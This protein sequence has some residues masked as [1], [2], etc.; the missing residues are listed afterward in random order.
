MSSNNNLS[1]EL[2]K[3]LFSPTDNYLQHELNRIILRARETLGGDITDYIFYSVNYMGKTYTTDGG[4]INIV[5]NDQLPES[6]YSRM[7]KYIKNTEEFKLSK[8][9]ISAY[10][11]RMLNMVEDP[12]MLNKVC[13]KPLHRTIMDFGASIQESVALTPTQLNL[14]EIFNDLNKDIIEEI[15][16]LLVKN[17]L[18]GNM[19]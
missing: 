18:I 16:A 9:R 15:N 1:F 13:P 4:Q 17:T 12:Y 11:R 10:I 5:C 2:Q 14:I 19:K 3:V 6:L 8:N 7:D